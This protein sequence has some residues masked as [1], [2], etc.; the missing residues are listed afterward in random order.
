M[1]SPE[2]LLRL[3]AEGLV[4]KCHGRSLAFER[5]RTP[6]FTELQSKKTNRKANAVR[7]CIL[8]LMGNLDT[9]RYRSKQREFRRSHSNRKEIE[10]KQYLLQGSLSPILREP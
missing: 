6:N 2:I 1:K 5:I 9:P 7:T 10:A 4:S 8:M 3:Q